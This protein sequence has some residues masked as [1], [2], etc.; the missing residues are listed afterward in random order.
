MSYVIAGYAIAL[1]T[2]AAYAARVLW[3]ERML[4]KATGESAVTAPSGGAA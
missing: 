4:R 1:S 2:I 3:R